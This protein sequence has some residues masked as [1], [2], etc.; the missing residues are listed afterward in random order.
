MSGS[1]EVRDPGTLTLHMS[2]SLY[3]HHDCGS[4][5]GSF[6]FTLLKS[7]PF[8]PEADMGFYP[9]G[10]RTGDCKAQKRRDELTIVSYQTTMHGMVPRASSRGGLMRIQRH[11]LATIGATTLACATTGRVVTGAPPSDTNTSQRAQPLLSTTAVA[12]TSPSRSE[13]RLRSDA[14]VRAALSAS[15]LVARLAQESYRPA[16]VTAASA[17]EAFAR[18]LES[19][20]PRCCERDRAISEILLQAK[21]LRD[22]D[23]LAFDSAGWAR[24]GLLAAVDALGPS[25]EAVSSVVPTRAWILRAR[26]SVTAIE[27]QWSF[28]FERA[29]LQEAFRSVAD[30]YLAAAPAAAADR[31]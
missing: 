15:D 7:G 23:D 27:G 28:T 30:A 2:V 3:W 24:T 4:R 1:R 18:A 5:V 21:H 6:D 12:L 13:D 17:L 19:A 16:R 11:L 10:A 8:R 14:F 20:R 9:S 29:R 26:S 22:E 25:N 31:C